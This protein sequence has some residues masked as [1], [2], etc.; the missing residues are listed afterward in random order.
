VKA[1]AFT[2]PV[3]RAAILVALVGAARTLPAQTPRDSGV[4]IIHA[5]RVFDS[6]KGAFVERKDIR[7]RNRTIE[8]VGDKLEVPAGARE[9]DLSAYSVLPGLIDVHTHLL[10]LEDPSGGDLTGEGTKALIREGTPL[11]ALHG[12]ARARTYLAAGITSVR[13]LGNSG[14]FGDVALKAAIADGS[15]DGPRMFVSGP[16]LSP[17]GGQFPGLQAGYASIAAEE[18]RIVHNPIDAAD[19]VRENVTYGA[20]VIK[21]YSNNTPNPTGLS[22]EE[23]VSIATTA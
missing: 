2:Q 22:P 10:Y 1:T 4:T 18:Y 11:R 23:L 8:A 17:V 12:A 21:V 14:R 7:V 16:G 9:V 15:V 6:E 3:L 13:D 19:A 5:G 20:D